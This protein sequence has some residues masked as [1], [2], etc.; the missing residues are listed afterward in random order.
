[1]DRSLEKNRQIVTRGMESGGVWETRQ[2]Y[3][4]AYTLQ[5]NWENHAEQR[6]RA[7]CLIRVW[8]GSAYNL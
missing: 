5:C 4:A 1:V 6:A 7:Q 2:R 3:I 8:C